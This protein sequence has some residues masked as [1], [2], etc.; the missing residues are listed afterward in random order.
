MICLDLLTTVH[1][2]NCISSAWLV[3]YTM[4][5]G[6]MEDN[7][8]FFLI[9]EKTQNK[10]KLLPKIEEITLGQVHVNTQKLNLNNL[11]VTAVFLNQ[12]RVNLWEHMTRSSDA[13]FIVCS[14]TFTLF[15]LIKTAVTVEIFWLSFHVLVLRWYLQFFGKSFHFPFPYFVFFVLWYFP[16]HVVSS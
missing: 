2:C 16:F 6:L 13:I 14:Q 9:F 3:K 4:V 10:G 11:M 15:W 1:Y 7:M 5:H 8:Y 12:K